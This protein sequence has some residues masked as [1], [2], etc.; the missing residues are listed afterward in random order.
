M[1]I[2][3]VIQKFPEKDR[4]DIRDLMSSIEIVSISNLQS[5]MY[6]AVNDTISE[7][8]NKTQKLV[9][10][11][12]TAESDI[13]AWFKREAKGS[14]KSP[15]NH[16][17]SILYK[18]FHPSDIFHDNSGSEHFSAI[19]RRDVISQVKQGRL[20]TKY[21]DIR[22]IN[23]NNIHFIYITDNSGSGRQI[24]DFLNRFNRSLGEII[25]S[26]DSVLVTIISW[27]ATR[28]A[29]EAINDHI[30]KILQGNLNLG[31]VLK[32]N[33]KYLNYINTITD[34][35]DSE[36]TER[37]RQVLPKYGESS[38]PLGYQSIASLTAFE[39]HKC[40]N[41]LPSILFHDKSTV[42]PLFNKKYV[43]SDV[44]QDLLNYFKEYNK[45]MFKDNHELRFRRAN[46]ISGSRVASASKSN[47]WMYL[48]FSAIG[49]SDTVAMALLNCS[50]QEKIRVRDG[51]RSMG[52][53]DP[54]GHATVEGTLA[55]RAY[56]RRNRH[57]VQR[58]FSKYEIPKFDDL[59]D[60]YY[61]NSIDG[62]SWLSG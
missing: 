30:K 50:Q 22:N 5:D 33:F 34:F 57:K 43:T 13:R 56:A 61:P 28:R 11:A 1:K 45:P 3:D 44:T 12:V 49:E 39:G 24:F 6:C 55:L 37:L 2:D 20:I 23:N 14:N 17:N 54:V 15:T 58:K 31:S 35:A 42:P 27:G 36:L 29:I 21:E 16:N 25:E 19:V 62:V 51:L 53:I 4:N 32:I 8:K 47:K 9:I 26:K 46:L 40:P 60:D 59:L 18:D 41:T 48:C 7:N 10:D 38:E 52:W